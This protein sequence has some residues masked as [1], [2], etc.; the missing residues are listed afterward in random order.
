M[1]VYDFE[2]D[3]IRLSDMGFVI[4]NFD[5]SQM[6]TT[7]SGSEIAF[8][9]VK[10]LNGCKYELANST[11]DTCLQ[12]IFSICKNSCNY[13]EDM[14][15]SID[16][17]RKL[18][19]WLN[20]K[21]FCEFRVLDNEY[22]DIYFEGSFNIS[23]IEMEGKL[24]G[25][26]LTLTTN[27]PFGLQNERKYIMK[28][29]NSNINYTIYDESDEIGYIYPRMK[30]TVGV[31]GNFSISNSQEPNRTMIINN[32]SKGEIIEVNYPIITTS[33]P[34]HDIY[35][36]FNW[37]FFRISNTFENNENKISAGFGE[38]EIVYSPIAKV[39]I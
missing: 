5:K 32:C 21:K 38:V 24:Y 34:T 16:E 27:R 17:Y 31:D 33:S 3:G 7:S 29:S 39:A 12:I 4:C 22:A 28:S 1:I 36:D 8:N 2:F 14:E 6:K 35:N 30:I 25:L 11:Y 15:I 9:T 23:K 18:M 26:E 20:R 19:R 37:E 10:T 13:L